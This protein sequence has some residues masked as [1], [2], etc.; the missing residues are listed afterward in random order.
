MDDIFEV[1]SI[2]E[3]FFK[4]SKY[5]DIQQDII[6]HSRYYYDI[7]NNIFNYNKKEIFIVC[8]CLSVK[9]LI[10]EA[11]YNTFYCDLFKINIKQFNKLELIILKKLKY[12]MN[13]RHIDKFYNKCKII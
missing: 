11:V 9:Y 5:I 2:D 12:K 1:F 7:V 13:I 4:V 6:D 3:I 8:V 10:D